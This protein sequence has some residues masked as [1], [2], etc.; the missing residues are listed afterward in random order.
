MSGFY[1]AIQQKKLG[2]KKIGNNCLISKLSR[3]ISKDIVIGNRCRIDDDVVFKGK[4]KLGDNVHIGRGCTISGGK[5][6]VFIDDFTGISNFVQIF[7]STDHY[8]SNYIPSATLSKKYQRKFSDVISKNI[9]IGKS[10]LIGSFAVIL[11]GCEIENF[12]SV[13]AH[14]VVYEKISEG[15][16]FNSNFPE[17]KTKK[18]DS[19]SIEKKIIKLVKELK[20]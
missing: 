6:G 8:S 15:T 14:N 17:K 11:P 20:K 19:K 16:S 4:V 12:S 2:L 5:K 9:K 10:V 1:S 13:G 3:F 7:T 18:R